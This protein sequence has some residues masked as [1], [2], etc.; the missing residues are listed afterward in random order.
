M[1][2]SKLLKIN[3]F[4]LFSL[5]LTAQTPVKLSNNQ[6]QF[7]EG[8]VWNGSNTI[9]FSDIPANKVVSYNINTK[10]FSDVFV[11]ANRPNGLMFNKDFDL[12]VCEGASGKITRRNVNGA[13]LETLTEKFMGIR[14]NGPNDLC[15]DKKGGIYFTDPNFESTSQTANRLYYRNNIGNV[16]Q[17][18]AFGRGKPNGVIISPD[19]KF[20]YLDNSESTAI[21]RYNINQITGRLTNRIRYG[22]LAG[23]NDSGADGMAVDTKGNL[24]VTSKSTV[25]VFDGSKLRAIKTIDFPEKTTNCTFGGVNKDVLFVTASKN[26]YSVSGLNVTGIQHPFDLAI[27]VTSGDNY[28]VEAESF[29]NTG[30]TFGGFEKYTVNGITAIN[31]NQT[32]DWV[33]YSITVAESDEYNVTYNIATPV[34]K[35]AIEFIVDGVSQLKDNVINNGSWDNFVALKASKTV[36]LT[37]GTRI[38]RLKGAGTS[39][40]KWEWNL[41]HFNLSSTT[42]G[43]KVLENKSFDNKFTIVQNSVED[44]FIVNGL[45]ENMKYNYTIINLNGKSINSG[46]ITSNNNSIKDLTILTKGV[47]FFVE[48][49][50]TLGARDIM[51]MYKN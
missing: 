4:A 36:F 6:F 1:N 25:Q 2:Y 7:V 28:T 29:V 31:F 22:T 34:N 32:G 10:T 15:I 24:Y 14:F 39:S 48:I 19:G 30:G 51:K 13:I 20:L 5:S 46:I 26:L 23:S 43:S 9:Y 40:G 11:N 42:L 44:S 12:I 33:E 41:D 18:D 47:V 45:E 49:N 35:T 50:N 38:I 17:Q 21:Y 8:P 3:V 16:I 37:K 27:T